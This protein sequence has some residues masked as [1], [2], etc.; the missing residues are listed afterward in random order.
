M[1][2]DKSLEVLPGMA[3]KATI[4]GKLPEGSTEL[5][6]EVPATAVFTSGDAANSY[7]WVVD[8]ASNTLNRREVEVGKLTDFGILVRSGLESGEVIVFKGV[9][10]LREGQKVKVIDDS[11]ARS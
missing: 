10:S 6:T 5:G 9:H 4:L 8:K 1:E 2:V 3:G 7:V 11:G